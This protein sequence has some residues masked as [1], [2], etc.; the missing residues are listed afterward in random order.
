MS[1]HSNLTIGALHFGVMVNQSEAE[2][3]I[4]AAKDKG[5]VFIDT[6]PLYGNGNSELIVGNCIK[7][8]REKFHLSTKVGLKKINRAD[9]S[10]G[11]GVIDLTPNNIKK[12]LENSLKNLQTDYIDLF[13]L[14]AFCET[15]PLVE[16]FG[17]LSDLVD[18]GKIKNIGVSNYNP[19]Q[20]GKVLSIIKDNNLKKIS[21]I[22]AHYNMVERMVE[23]QLVPQCELADIKIMPYRALGRGLLSD[24]YLN[25]IPSDSR[26]A[27]SWRVKRYLNDNFLMLLRSLNNLA[28]NYQMTLAS[29][30]LHWVLNKE[31]VGNVL[32]GVRD[33]DSLEDCISATLTKIPW[34]LEE[35]IDKRIAAHG[36]MPWVQSNPE[37][38]FEQ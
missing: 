29:L 12:S 13:Y 4:D 26:A 2:V 5:V 16:T 23:N 14:H 7:G 36:L 21:C 17:A 11:V 31:I 22:E 30:S 15:V 20:L 35:E 24:K 6:G 37:V 27:S 34:E 8:K 28:L 18:E 9:G 19:E 3:I 32:I 10:F 33:V 1:S 25:G 38:Y